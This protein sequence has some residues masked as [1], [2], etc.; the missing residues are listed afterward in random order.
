MK[1]SV[2]SLFC[3]VGHIKKKRKTLFRN[4]DLEQYLSLSHKFNSDKDALENMD[5]TF[6]TLSSMMN[7]T[8]SQ[9]RSWPCHVVAG[10][11]TD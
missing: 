11:M 4:G 1:M 8:V 7:A 9:K 5:K 6:T 2:L 10:E 3:C